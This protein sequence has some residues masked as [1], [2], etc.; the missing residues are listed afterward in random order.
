MFL[1]AEVAQLSLWAI[2]EQTQGSDLHEAL[3]IKKTPDKDGK[4][5][6]KA[7]GKTSKWTL[8]GF[9]FVKIHTE[10]SNPQLTF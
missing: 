10:P 3:T 5:Q 6:L 1:G 8:S 4:M 7:P 2:L 9:L